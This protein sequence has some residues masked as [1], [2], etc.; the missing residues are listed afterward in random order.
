M[1]GGRFLELLSGADLVLVD[2]TGTVTFGKPSIDEVVS[3]GDLSSEEVLSLAAS[4]ER[5]SSHPL[6]W[7]VVAEAQKRGLSLKEPEAFSEETGV[8]VRAT[9]EG[10]VVAVGRTEEAALAAIGADGRGKAILHQWAT[11]GKTGI[12]VWIDGKLAG[13]LAAVDS[14]RPEVTEAIQSLK[15]MGLEVRIVTGDRDEVAATIAQQL[16]VEYRAGLLP[17]QKVEVVKAYQAQGRRVVMVGDGI[18]DAAALVQADVGIAMMAG[19]VALP[20]EVSHVVLMRDDWTL[21]PW[22]VQLARKTM[23]TVKLNLGF[24][25]LYNL[26]G[27]GLAFSGLLPPAVAASAQSLPDVAI[28]ANS[29]R[30]LGHGSERAAL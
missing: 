30:L 22:L 6:A 13:A 4:A 9:V 15:S 24:T 5:Y 11:E 23:A 2:K 20:A 12:L 8:G 21:V 7:A 26:L 16:E 19:G 1:R 17:H 3:L 28:L 14:L 25:A 10:R 29:S 18:N 27:V